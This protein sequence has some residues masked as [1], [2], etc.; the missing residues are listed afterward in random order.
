M[1]KSLIR[2]LAIVAAFVVGYMMPELYVYKWTFKWFLM[3]MLFMTFL[4]IRFSRVLVHRNHWRIQA[5]NLPIC[6]LSWGA[7]LWIFGPGEMAEAAFFIGIMPTAIAAPVIMGILGGSVE[8]VLT[9]L[10]IT[11]GVI[12]AIMPLILPTVI[13]HGG[14]EIYLDVALNVV[15]V[16]LAPLGLAWLVRRIWPQSFQWSKKL[17]NANIVTLSLVLILKASNASHEI[18]SRSNVSVPVLETMALMSLLICAL[19]FTVG[20]FIAR[21]QYAPESGQ[22]LGQK[23]TNITIYLA[24]TYASPIAVLGPTFYVLWHNLWNA[25]QLYRAAEKK[26]KGR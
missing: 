19:N 15:L 26:R 8:F 6:L 11:N 5:A 23:N 7:A 17:K 18:S 9:S 24:L 16:M 4:G 2:T 1:T 14:L 10:L 12:C 13:G 20:H 21:G 3:L 22:A 25:F